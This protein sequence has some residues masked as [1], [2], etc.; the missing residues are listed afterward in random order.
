MTGGFGSLA[1]V[2]PIVEQLDKSKFK[3]VFSIAH[4][5]A[6]AVKKMQYDFIPYPDAGTPELVT[7]KG[8]VW[9]D[10]DHYWGRFGFADEKYFTRLVASRLRMVE[11]LQP[12]ILLTQFCPPTEIIA[13][14]TG[15]PLVCVTQSCWHPKGK[16]LTWWEPQQ[17]DYARVTPV[18]NSILK[19]Y[20]AP[21]IERME[22]LNSGNLTIIPGFPE[23]DPVHD[24]V[25]YTGPLQWDSRPIMNG[26]KYDLSS[27]D[28]KNTILVYTGH[29]YDT[30]GDSG[31]LI[32]E[33]IVESLANTKYNV[34]LTTG[35]GQPLDKEKYAAS[36]IHLFDWLPINK[37]IDH[38]GL[39]IH[40]GGHGS[41]MAS[42]LHGVPSLVIPTFQEREYNAR[43][44]HLLGLADFILPHEL[45]AAALFSKIE[46]SFNN[47]PLLTNALH[48]KNKLIARNYNGAQLA[49]RAIHQLANN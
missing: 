30:G 14:I 46:S 21:S 12:D 9:C 5:A 17:M 2:L 47:T 22:D 28:P 1:Q 40:H 43:Q 6:H 42:V 29:L 35:L 45:T 7:P 27:F 36:N 33:K 25:L 13:R 26:A 44:L 48:W 16:S 10:L 31:I 19:K 18:V 4:G 8:R 39:F 3:V 34:L 20:G 38:C 32:L 23:F 41:C 49:A 37:A 24:E 15:I 11:E